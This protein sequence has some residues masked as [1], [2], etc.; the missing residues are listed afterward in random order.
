MKLYTIIFG[1]MLIFL[2]IYNISQV[3]DYNEVFT[4]IWI[5]LAIIAFVK[6]AWE[7]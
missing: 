4:I 1:I 3:Y 6:G 5:G 7:M 2:A